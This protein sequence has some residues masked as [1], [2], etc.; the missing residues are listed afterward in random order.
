MKLDACSEIP[1]SSMKDADMLNL[2]DEDEE[3]LVEPRFKYSRI[4]SDVSRVIF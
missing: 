1:S 3:V 4:L 2:E